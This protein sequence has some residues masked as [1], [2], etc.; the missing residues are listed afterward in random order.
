MGR[1][2]QLWSP[3]EGPKL[4]SR[5]A[6]NTTF[7]VGGYIVRRSA[8]LDAVSREVDVL[9]ALAHAT[10]VPTP[11]PALHEAE[12]GTFAYPRLRGTPLLHRSQRDLGNILPALIDA[13][14]A[15]RRI[16]PASRL[17]VDHYPNEEWRNDAIQA[18]QS[19]R[20]HLSAEQERRVHRFLDEPAPPTR[21]LAV[22]QHNDLGAEHILV[23][24]QG[25]LSGIID[26]TDAALTDPARDI[27][28]IY[29]DFGPDAAAFVG[30]AL[31]GPLTEDEARRVRF[32]ARCRWLEDVAFGIGDPLTR[33]PY[34]ENAWGTFDHTF[35]NAI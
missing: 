27:G 9:N 11:A 23:D 8:D 18:F 33:K 6:E 21:T 30:E 3:S 31:N 34:L 4:V 25:E 32:H 13:L 10:S 5:G 29:R 20:K 22:A 24:D 26:W 17:P 2:Y 7:A 35:S 16:L 12:L 19:V 15:L 1:R 14:S 28:S